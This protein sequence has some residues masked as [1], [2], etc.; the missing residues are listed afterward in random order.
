[1]ARSRLCCWLGAADENSVPSGRAV[2]PGIRSL[3]VGSPVQRFPR[4]LGGRRRLEFSRQPD[5]R[6]GV[7]A[8]R[9]IT[10]QVRDCLPFRHRPTHD[11]AERPSRENVAWF[12]CVR[13]LQCPPQTP[14]CIWAQATAEGTVPL[15]S[16][17]L[18]LPGQHCATLRG[19][20]AGS[21]HHVWLGDTRSSSCADRCVTRICV[22]G[23]GRH[24]RR[25][26][27]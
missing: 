15:R 11:S 14:S 18:D 8:P 23:T 17:S 3:A 9:L 13:R 19:G 24:P 6:D 22:S 10:W 27:V 20:A 4:E 12:P 21:R 16:L 26:V 25:M 7:V 2:V 1:M 5:R